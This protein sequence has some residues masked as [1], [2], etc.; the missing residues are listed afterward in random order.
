[1]AKKAVFQFNLYGEAENGDE[2][3]KSVKLEVDSVEGT[4]EQ[5]MTFSVYDRTNGLDARIAFPKADYSG[6][7]EALTAISEN[8]EDVERAVRKA[9]S[10]L[11][12][13]L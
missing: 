1:M 6:M 4:A 12:L 8:P 9:V 10:L 3:Q 11:Q 5:Q 13:M 2:P 7:Q